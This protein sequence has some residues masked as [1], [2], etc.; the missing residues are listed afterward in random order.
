[1]EGKVVK[2]L[3]LCGLFWGDQE[4]STPL[5]VMFS[6]WQCP[7]SWGTRKQKTVAQST[8]EAEYMSLLRLQ[9]KLRG[10]DFIGGIGYEL[11]SPYNSIVTTR[12]Q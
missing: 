9:T 6:C 4:I 7:I 8:T 10:T 11:D 2:P 5:R 1:M 12:V 3:W